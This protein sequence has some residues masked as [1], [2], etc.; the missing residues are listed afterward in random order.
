MQELNET[1]GFSVEIIYATANNFTN[2]VL[3]DEPICMLR[4]KTAQKLINANNKLKEY[5]L[6]IKIW[7]SF[8]PLEYQRK[9]F[10][11][12]PD[13][14]FVANP[15]KKDC[16][17]CAVDVTLCTLDGESIEMPTE[18]DH[19]GVESYRNYYSNLTEEVRKNALILEN[20]MT[21]CGFL[22][23]STEWWHFNDSEDYDVIREMYE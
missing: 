17:G 9:M 20:T 7:D 23:L 11:I 22:P 8:R 12:Y 15:D 18:F 6:K 4:E 19:F 16:K 10:C 2:E 3:Y 13:E 5:G 21:E 14:N 1:D